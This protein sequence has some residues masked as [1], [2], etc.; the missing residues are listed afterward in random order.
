MSTASG[1]NECSAMATWSECDDCECAKNQAGCDAYYALEDEHCY[2][3]A[4]APCAQQCAASA[5][6]GMDFDATCEA[7]ASGL[8][9]TCYDA[10][11]TACESDADCNAFI[12]A[13][14]ASCDALPDQ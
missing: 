5:C 9:D 3:G 10:A 4:M 12:T 2:C 11:Y 8:D 6:A 13:S 14:S 1:G 7:C